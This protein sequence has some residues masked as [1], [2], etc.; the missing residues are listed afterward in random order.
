VSLQPLGLGPGSLVA[1]VPFFAAAEAAARE[2]SGAKTCAILKK[3]FALGYVLGLSYFLATFYWI[4][5]LAS[6]QVRVPGLMFPALAL[7]VGY[8]SLYTGLFGAAFVF[9]LVRKPSLAVIAAGAFWTL[10]EYLR[11]LGVLGFPW[12]SLGY[13]F[14]EYPSFIQIS[15]FASVLG[16]SFWIVVV[17]RLLWSA[18]RAREVRKALIPGIGASVLFL[19]VFIQGRLVL[20]RTSPTEEMPVAMI[21]PNIRPEIKW[22]PALKDQHMQTYVDMTRELSGCGAGLLIWPE[23]ATPCF[24]RHVRR[25]ESMVRQV[26]RS[27]S[28]SILTGFPDWER[29]GSDVRYY[30]AAGLIGPDGHWRAEYKKMHLVPFSEALPLENRFSF[31]KR[32][33]LGQAHFSAGEDFTLFEAGGKRF[34]VLI[35][36]ESIFP[37]LARTFVSRGADFLVNITNDGWFGRTSASGQHASMAVF[38]AV[39]NRVPIARCANTGVSMLIDPWGRVLERRGLFVRSTICAGLPFEHPGTFYTRHGRWV[40]LVP[41]VLAGVILLLSFVEGRRGR[42]EPAGASHSGD[43]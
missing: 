30:N 10:S 31:L 20:N 28:L 11:S 3:G 15:S 25:Y 43:R 22:N 13:S 42:S 6:D 23:T 16:V 40:E 26:A 1:L 5:F 12:A 36:F 18:L 41:A 38:R 34:G 8:L 2:L 33:D 17:N 9:S 14:S 32:I 35:C 21:Q 37:A 24:L 29:V 27:E 39:E 4:L 7:M 19:A